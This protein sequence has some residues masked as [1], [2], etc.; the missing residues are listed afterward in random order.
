MLKSLAM[1][2]DNYLIPRKLLCE[3]Y[4]NTNELIDHHMH[5]FESPISVD[6][7][8]ALRQIIDNFTNNIRSLKLLQESVDQ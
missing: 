7:A 5:Y 6:S 8:N 1:S 4:E 3:R 2:D